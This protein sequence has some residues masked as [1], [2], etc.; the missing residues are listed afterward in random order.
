MGKGMEKLNFYLDWI[1]INLN[2]GLNHMKKKILV[3]DDRHDILYA[4][5]RGLETVADSFEVVSAENGKQCLE[6]LTNNELPD[7]ILLDIMM[8]GMNGWELFTIIKENK[9]WRN[10]PI[11]F[12][13]AKTD[14]FSQGFGKISADEYITK[15]FELKDVIEKINRI[16]DN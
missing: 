8:P 1:I 13:T 4:V 9:E 12:L 7:V 10:I 16:I 5:I 3:V 6:L 15:P 2:R 11:L 14:G